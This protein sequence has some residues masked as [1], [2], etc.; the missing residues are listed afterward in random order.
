MFV[1]RQHDVLADRHGTEQGTA[2]EGDA[3]FLAQVEHLLLAGRADILTEQPDR[4]RCLFFKGHQV[5]K[6]GALARTAAAHDDHDFAFRDVHR[7]AVE[8][9]AGAV[10]GDQV[11]D[12]DD[13]VRFSIHAFTLSP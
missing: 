11:F 5:S 6:Q 8:N 1:E 9:F 4:S 10:M 7:D 13:N 2:L 12:F 3:D